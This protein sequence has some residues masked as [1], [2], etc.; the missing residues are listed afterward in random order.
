MLVGVT[1]VEGAV[2]VDC[3]D[4]SVVSSEGGVDPE[5]GCPEQFVCL[6]HKK[7]CPCSGGV[8]ADKYRSQLT[9]GI[10]LDSS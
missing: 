5:S 4:L 7:C 2:L 8:P 3:Q 10:L 1:V 6:C 9:D